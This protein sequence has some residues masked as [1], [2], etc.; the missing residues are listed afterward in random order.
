MQNKSHLNQTQQEIVEKIE[1]FI[2]KKLPELNQIESK[3]RGILIK[4]GEIKGLGLF[5][6][7]L[8]EFL[9]SIVKISSL[10][11]LSLSKNPIKELSQ[12]FGELKNLVKLY[13]KDT[14]IEKF[15]DS[16]HAMLYNGFS[17]EDFESIKKKT[18]SLISQGILKDLQ[19]FNPYE[20]D[21]SNYVSAFGQEKHPFVMFHNLISKISN[22][23]S[24]IVALIFLYILELPDSGEEDKVT[25]H[26][27]FTYDDYYFKIRDYL[28]GNIP[29]WTLAGLMK[30]GK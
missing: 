7:G 22:L 26:T 16:F 4:N 11:M 15:P 5:D 27:F 18:L 25:W 29:T 30:E 13:L 19:F 3:S 8:T 14:E 1:S 9:E 12:N 10:E 6:C 2:G 17:K 23:P 24:T 28:F 20:M 21:V